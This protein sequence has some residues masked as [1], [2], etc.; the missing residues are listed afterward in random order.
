MCLVDANVNKSKV[1]IEDE[2]NTTNNLKDTNN[3]N[4]KDAILNDIV[5]L[6]ESTTEKAFNDY[7]DATTE[8]II[9]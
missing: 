1:Q 4:V 6:C 7:E 2:D 3:F 8:G 9:I 5:P